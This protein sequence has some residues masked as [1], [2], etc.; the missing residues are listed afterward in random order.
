L[1]AE[2]ALVSIMLF[3]GALIEWNM[4]GNIPKKPM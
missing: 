1:L 3:I 2:I 4:I